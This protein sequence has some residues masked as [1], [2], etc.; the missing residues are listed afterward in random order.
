MTRALQDLAFS[1]YLLLMFFIRPLQGPD[2]IVE[3][4]RDIKHQNCSNCLK[5]M[6][7]FVLIVFYC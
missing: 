2:L 6:K 1:E 5:S 4:L 7:F 3:R